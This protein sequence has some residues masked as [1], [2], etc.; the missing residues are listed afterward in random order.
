[1]KPKNA[2]EQECYDFISGDQKGLNDTHCFTRIIYN[3]RLCCHLGVAPSERK[4]P[5]ILVLG[6]NGK[7]GR[8]VVKLLKKKNFRIIEV[9]SIGHFN[10]FINDI[11]SLFSSVN[12]TTVIDVTRGKE[13]L[14]EII[15]NQFRNK[16][17][18]PIIRVVNQFISKPGL[19]QIK[20]R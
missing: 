14:H 16:R 12:I 11:Y 13:N 8:E 18:I 6:S 10:L 19:V 20:Y 5:H 17:G 4:L 15:Y 3:N 9:K 1:M 7:I 2:F